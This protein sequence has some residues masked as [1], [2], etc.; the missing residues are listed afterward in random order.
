MGVNGAGKSTLLKLV[1][2]ESKP[3]AGNATIGAS[4]KLGYFAQHS[5]E[6]LDAKLTVLETLAGRLPA[7]HRRLAEDS[8]SARSASRAKTRTSRAACCQVARR[9][10]WCW[11]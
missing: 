9:R 3:D 6:L 4:V 5:M 7:R 8:G 10:A 11:R 1:A 2:G